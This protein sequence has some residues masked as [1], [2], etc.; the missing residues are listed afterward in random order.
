MYRRDAYVSA[1][2]YFPDNGISCIPSK[3]KAQ[4]AN[5]NQK[6][7]PMTITS[8]VGGQESAVPNFYIANNNNEFES[9]SGSN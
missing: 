1:E 2:L 6:I 7:S 3:R 9:I 8:F 4:P 5:T